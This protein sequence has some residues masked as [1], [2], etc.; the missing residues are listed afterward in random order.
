MKLPTRPD[1][2]RH[3]ELKMLTTKPEVG[4]NF[5]GKEMAKRFHRQPTHFSTLPDI[6]MA[7]SDTARHRSTSGTQNVDHHTASNMV[8]ILGS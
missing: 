2:R 8:A 3:P 5:E 4:L 1:N 7:F 6:N